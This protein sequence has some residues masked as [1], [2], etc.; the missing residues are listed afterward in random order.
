ML[1]IWK[2]DLLKPFFDVVQLTS[3]NSIYMDRS[4]VEILEYKHQ[5][6][7]FQAELNTFQMSNFNFA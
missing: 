4:S 3:G 6:E 2:F 5:I 7:I 1:V